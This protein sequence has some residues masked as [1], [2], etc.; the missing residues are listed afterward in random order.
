MICGTSGR[1]TRVTFMFWTGG[2]VAAARLCMPRR[3]KSLGAPW[4]GCEAVA[5]Y[6]DWNDSS[7]EPRPSL[8]MSLFSVSSCVTCL[9]AAAIASAL[10]VLDGAALLAVV[11]PLADAVPLEAGGATWAPLTGSVVLVELADIEENAVV[12]SVMLSVMP[13]S[14]PAQNIGRTADESLFHRKS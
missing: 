1:K 14:L 6:V 12:E 4:G 13:S 11:V 9:A 2:G 8:A 5:S 10:L 3:R 7:L